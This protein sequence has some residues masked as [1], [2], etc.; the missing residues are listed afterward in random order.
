ML[1]RYVS[2]LTGRGVRFF[3]EAENDGYI[4]NG[5]WDPDSNTINI[6]VKSKNPSA[7]KNRRYYTTCTDE[8]GHRHGAVGQSTLR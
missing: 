3:S 8:I 1:A 4:N 5:F 2:S 6:N 7:C